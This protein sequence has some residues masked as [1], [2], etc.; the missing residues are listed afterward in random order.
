MLDPLRRRFLR[1]PAGR[2]RAQRLLYGSDWSML[3]KEF[4]YADYLPVVAHMYRRKIHSV[5]AGARRNARAF[6][7]GNAIR[8]LGLR[9]GERTRARLEAW[10]SRHGLDADLLARFD[11]VDA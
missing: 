6:L 10:Y 11:A 7:C 3:A 2:V 4:Y 8:F 5:G 9:K 1:P